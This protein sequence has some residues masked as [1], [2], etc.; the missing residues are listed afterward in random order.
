MEK[1]DVVVFYVELLAY[2]DG[3]VKSIVSVG[4]D[5]AI[6]LKN[7]YDKVDELETLGHQVLVDEC[8]LGIL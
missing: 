8:R 1:Y 2:I 6:C 3:E 7:A 4:M 5:S